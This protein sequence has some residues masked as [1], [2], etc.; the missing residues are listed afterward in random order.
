MICHRGQ[1]TDYVIAQTVVLFRQNFFVAERLK[2]LRTLNHEHT[3]SFYSPSVQFAFPQ[4]QKP[5]SSDLLKR[6]YPFALRI[7]GKSAQRKLASYK[8]PHVVKFQDEV[9]LLSLKRTTWKQRRNVLLSE[10]GLQLITVITPP[11]LI[12]CLD[13]E[14]FVLVPASVHNKSAH[15]VTKQELPK[16]KTEKPPTY[17]IDSLNLH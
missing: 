2:H 3:K 15:S 5:F 1:T 4:M 17:Q 11:S 16:Y 6:V 8:K 14:Q 10:K 7:H 12:I 13:M 9:W